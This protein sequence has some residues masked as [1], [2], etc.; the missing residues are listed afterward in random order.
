MPA[1][2]VPWL[3]RLVGRSGWHC[4]LTRDGDESAGAGALFVDGEHAWLGFGATRPPF[5][6]RGSQSALF[7]RRIAD[8]AL[9]GARHVST[10]TGVPQPGQPAPSY[11]NILRAGFEVAYVRPNWSERS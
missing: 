1:S 10:E 5:R 7:H 3:A 4:Y 8:A 6:K 11:A 9:H 2:M